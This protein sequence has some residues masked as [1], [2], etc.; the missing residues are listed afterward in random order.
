[1]DAKKS[2]R[3]LKVRQKLGGRI[4]DLIKQAGYPSVEGFALANGFHKATIHQLIKATADPRF[5]TLLR[6]SE[7]LEIPLDDL[8]KGLSN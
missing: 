3:I 8:V 4:A 5:S 1:V 7:A 2:T 6:L